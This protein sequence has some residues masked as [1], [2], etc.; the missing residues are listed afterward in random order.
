MGV[1]AMQSRVDESTFTRRKFTI[2]ESLDE[3][4]VEFAGRHYQG[5]VSLCI[6]SAIEDHQQSLEG[7]E[8]LT[9]SRLVAQIG[10]L[11]NRQASIHEQLEEID[12]ALH[13]QQGSNKATAPSESSTNNTKLIQRELSTADDGLRIDDLMERLSLNLPEIQSALGSL[14]DQGVVTD[15]TTNRE[16]FWIVGDRE[17]SSRE[18]N[19]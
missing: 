4:L 15:R 12:D 7:K 18:Y 8:R 17:S 13:V 16:R 3:R 2:T 9:L 19:E 14:V 1:Y 10:E 6:R 11:E 5:N